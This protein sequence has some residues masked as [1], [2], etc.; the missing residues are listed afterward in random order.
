MLLVDNFRVTLISIPVSRNKDH[1][2][3]DPVIKFTIRI[4]QSLYSLT[5][6]LD[7]C[8][9]LPF[10][11][12]AESATEDVRVGGPLGVFLAPDSSGGTGFSGSAAS[13]RI[14]C[15]SSLKQVVILPM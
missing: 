14:T 5:L 12:L 8:M 6:F 13:N 2:P 7:D 15:P 1:I 9:R 10:L 4:H 11:P 3:D